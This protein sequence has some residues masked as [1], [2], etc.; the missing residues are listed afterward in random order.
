[1]LWMLNGE[2]TTDA[3]PKLKNSGIDQDRKRVVRRLIMWTVVNSVSRG[4][5]V[6]FIIRD[7]LDE[8]EVDLVP[9]E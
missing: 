3:H 8:I 6:R 7:Y 1:M 9:E 4:Q 2:G 5:A